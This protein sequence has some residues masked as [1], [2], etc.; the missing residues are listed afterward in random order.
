MVHDHMICQIGSNGILGHNARE[1]PIVV[2]HP[3]PCHIEILIF[4]DI[5]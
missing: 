4:A 1:G 5:H 2:V 3:R